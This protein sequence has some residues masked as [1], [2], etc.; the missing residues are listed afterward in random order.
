MDGEDLVEF[1]AAIARLKSATKRLLLGD[2][3]TND[4]LFVGGELRG[5]T[6]VTLAQRADL[7]L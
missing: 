5:G 1:L 7:R 4:L 3:L 6:G 2:T